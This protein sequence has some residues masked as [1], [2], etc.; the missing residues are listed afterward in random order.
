MFAD[1]VHAVD[2]VVHH[3]V[4]LVG[5]SDRTLG[6][7][8]R[9]IGVGRHPV[10]GLGHV[11]HRHRGIADLLGLVLGGLGQ[12]TRG[13]L[14]VL[15]GGGD[16]LGAE[17]DGRHQVAQ[18][19]N[20]IIDRIGDGA[21][22]VLGHRDRHGQVAIGEVFDFV[23]QAHDCLLV[24]FILFAGFAQLPVRGTH[25]HQADKDD[26]G[27]RQQAQ[28]V[29]ADSIQGSAV[30]QVLETGGQARGFI[31]QGLRQAEDAPGGFAHTEQFRRGFEDFVHGAGDELKQLGDLGQ[32]R[33]G[34]RVLHAGNLDR[35]VTAKHGFEH[36]AKTAGVAAEGIRGLHGGL[37]PASTV[38]TEPR[39]RSASSD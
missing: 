11:A 38:L 31:E 3:L 32:P 9:L 4:A 12:L 39:I 6:H 21:G 22:E 30:G 18:L 10:D 33:A 37:I 29:A 25:H 27:Q 7:L 24:A 23:E 1:V 2:G 20:G 26:R 19:V 15:H 5:D 17:V 28:H 16:F 8:R 34:V 14:G 36:L 35:L 13:V